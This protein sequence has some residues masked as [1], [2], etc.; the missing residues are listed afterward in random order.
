M[1]NVELFIFLIDQFRRDTGLPPTRNEGSNC[2]AYAP[3]VHSP[4]FCSVKSTP[5]CSVLTKV[6]T[7]SISS[8]AFQ[9]FVVFFETY[10]MRFSFSLI[11]L[12]SSEIDLGVAAF[13]SVQFYPVQFNPL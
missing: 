10:F 3:R 7:R 6:V 2:T 12:T 4:P 8:I 13:N 9:I 1:Q 5:F 11:C